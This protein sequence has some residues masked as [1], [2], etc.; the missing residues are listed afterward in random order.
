MA[1]CCCCCEDTKATASKRTA[2][3]AFILSFFRLS[4][5][6]RLMGKK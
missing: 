1:N 2:R 4:S 6:K 5:A 3:T